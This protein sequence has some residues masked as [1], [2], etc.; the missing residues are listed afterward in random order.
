MQ[1]PADPFKLLEL[2]FR[3]L[4]REAATNWR[5]RRHPVDWFIGRDRKQRREIKMA[6]ATPKGGQFEAMRVGG[7]ALKTLGLDLAQQL[8]A[9]RT[10]NHAYALTGVGRVATFEQKD[11]ITKRGYG[12]NPPAANAP[13][14]DML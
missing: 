11:R 2:F 12:C 6:S 5:C 8:H 14:D 7:E 1:P 9:S 3:I 13:V 4:T 10:A